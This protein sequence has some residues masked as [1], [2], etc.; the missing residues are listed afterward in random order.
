MSFISYVQLI[1]SVNEN[2]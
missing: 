1:V 2:W